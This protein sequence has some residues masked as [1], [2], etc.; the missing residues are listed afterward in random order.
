[1]LPAESG[2]VAR[3]HETSLL[4]YA[5]RDRAPSMIACSIHAHAHS[6]V[7]LQAMQAVNLATSVKRDTVS[8]PSV[9]GFKAW[10]R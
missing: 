7:T 9:K 8:S 1:M 3:I 6:S 5:P 2:T 10:I 4:D